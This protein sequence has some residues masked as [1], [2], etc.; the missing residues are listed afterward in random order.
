MRR[1]PNAYSAAVLACTSPAFGNAK[2][3]LQ[4]RFLAQRLDPLDAG[5]TMA[6]LAPALVAALWGKGAERTARATAIAVMSAVPPDTYRAAI[7]CLV[8]FDERANLSRI[9]V[10]TLCL[11]GDQDLSAPAP[12]MARM[13]AKIAGARFVCLKGVGHLANLEAPEA[14]AEAVVAFL[15]ALPRVRD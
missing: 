6:E 9:A 12:M 4:A 3:A 8:T 10:P 2:G 15:R 7:R 5:R 14:F 13:A 1:R 11:A